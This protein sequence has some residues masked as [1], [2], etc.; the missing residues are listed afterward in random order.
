MQNYDTSKYY[1]GKLC[2]NNHNY[3]N[4]DKCLRRKNGGHCIDCERNR[5]KRPEYKLKNKQRCKDWRDRQSKE[6]KDRVKLLDAEK[7]RFLRLND[8]NTIMTGRLHSKKTKALKKNNIVEN[9][10]P[11]DFTNICNK[12]NNQCAYCGIIFNNIKEI[13]IEHVIPISKKGSH[14]VNNIVPSCKKCNAS[15]KAQLINEWYV[16]Q[17]FYN[18]QRHRNIKMHISNKQAEYKQ[19]ELLQSWQYD[20]Y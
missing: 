5:K 13:E 11:S 16:N 8:Y 2:Q 1:L 19:Q 10:S 17:S 6:Y 7:K 12:F 3:L 20:V 14:S 4:T 18:V 15:K 9:V